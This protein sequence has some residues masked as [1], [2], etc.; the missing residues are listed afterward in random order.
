MPYTT[1]GKCIYKSDTG[2]KVGCTKGSIK[3]YL[4]ALHANA[5]ESTLIESNLNGI[6]DVL[7][8]KYGEYLKGLNIYENRSSLILS[9]IVIKDEYK[10]QGIG[11]K[12][13]QDLVNYADKTKKIIALTP[14]SDFGGNKNRLIQFYKRFGFKHNKGVHKNFE[15]RE[16]MIRYP[17]LN[18]TMEKVK[19]GLADGMTTKDIAEKHGVSVKE[20]S[21]QLNKGIKVE[22]EHTDSD[23]IAKEI[24]LD[25]LYE[26]PK[27]YDKLKKIHNESTQRK[28]IRKLVRE[29]IELSIIDE[30][31]DSHTY[32]IYYNNRKVGYITC[33]PASSRV[34]DNT[35]HEIIDLHLED[36]YANL[37]VAN[38]AV[39]AL[40]NVHPN[41]QRLVVSIPPNSRP[42][43]EKLGFNRLNDNYYFLMR[44]H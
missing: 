14:A 16:I 1:K 3:K 5:N 13:M 29:A 19:G 23:I 6:Q 26:D 22:L 34:F 37:N 43:W 33:G 4:A 31:K 27:Y 15:F 44:G 7:Q 42:F 30:T 39:R 41:V 32:D 21:K 2:K 9:K 25:H 36:E 24:A 10:N 20:I 8:E 40:W 17:K 35:T 28:L 38:Q 11:S 18:E 12:I